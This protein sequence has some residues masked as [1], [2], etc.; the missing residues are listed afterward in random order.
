MRCICEVLIKNIYHF[1]PAPHNV[2]PCRLI[3]SRQACIVLQNSDVRVFVVKVVLQE[4]QQW[5]F[6]EVCSRQLTF[7]HLHYLVHVRVRMQELAI[8]VGSIGGQ[9]VHV[10]DADTQSPLPRVALMYRLQERGETSEGEG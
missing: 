6:G 8:G 3:A 4:G 2:L 10:P 5:S 9:K 7:Q 1:R